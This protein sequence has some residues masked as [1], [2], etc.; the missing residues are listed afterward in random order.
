MILLE[1]CIVR[2][3]LLMVR[4]KIQCHEFLLHYNFL[5]SPNPIPNTAA[6]SRRSTQSDAGPLARVGPSMLWILYHGAFQKLRNALY[7]R[8]YAISQRQLPSR[9]GASSVRP[10]T[11]SCTRLCQMSESKTITYMNLGYSRMTNE[12]IP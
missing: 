1:I 12:A 10:A 6:F 2:C 8:H 4:G 5:L 11:C 7:P 3:N 9:G